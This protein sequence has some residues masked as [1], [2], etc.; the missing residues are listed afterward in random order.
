METFINNFNYIVLGLYI[1]G[2]LL[3]LKR[4]V[5]NEKMSIDWEENFKWINGWISKSDGTE[6]KFDKFISL[7][8]AFNIFYNLY[9]RTKNPQANLYNNNENALQVADL[10]KINPDNL[11]LIKDFYKYVME[12]KFTLENRKKENLLKKLNE[13]LD[14]YE[15]ICRNEKELLKISLECLYIVRCNLLHGVKNVIKKQKILM[16]NSTNLLKSFLEM[17]RIK[18]EENIKEINQ[19]G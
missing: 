3:V 16:E 17:A 11:G 15:K 2:G 5:L 19:N 9:A 6:D 10:L 1:L 4:G 14:S 18:Y 7:F 12:S 8:I 13:Q